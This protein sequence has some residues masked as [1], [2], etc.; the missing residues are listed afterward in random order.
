MESSTPPTD[1]FLGPQQFEF[2]PEA[3]H[4][5]DPLAR[6]LCNTPHL[7]VDYTKLPKRVFGQSNITTF[8]QHIH[9]LCHD[10]Q[11]DI[12][13]PLENEEANAIGVLRA[14]FIRHESAGTVT[15][16]AIGFMLGGYKTLRI[17]DA[18]RQQMATH[19]FHLRSPLRAVIRIGLCTSIGK[20]AGAALETAYATIKGHQM[21]NADPV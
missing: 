10:V 12:Q 19:M 1:D 21:Q 11:H 20:P 6:N 18:T 15:G 9:V 8:E 14:T 3:S 5:S 17:L 13:R 2:A 4:K 7:T 16:T